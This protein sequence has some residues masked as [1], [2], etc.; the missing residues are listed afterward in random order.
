MPSIE[1]AARL[2]NALNLSLDSLCGLTDDAA[3]KE[4]T[5]LAHQ[6][7]SLPANQLAALKTLL[8]ALL[9]KTNGQ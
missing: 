3:D 1:A 9:D 7:A 4:W 5:T 6:A 2:V 8:N